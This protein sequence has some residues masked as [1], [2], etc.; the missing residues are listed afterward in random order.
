M[1][2]PR[3]VVFGYGPNGR[4]SL[5]ALD[6]L[7]VTP[8]AVVVPGNRTGHDIDVVRQFAGDRGWPVLEQPRRAA[9]APFLDTI[10]ALR[11]DLLFVWSYSMLLPA[12]LIGIAPLGAVNL[13]TG[14]LPEYRGGHVL[15]WAIINGERETGVT[16]AFLDEGVDTGPVIAERRFPIEWQDDAATVNE[17]LRV[18]GSELIR[19]WWPVIISGK[20]PR[21]PQDESR[22]R[23]YRM[24]GPDDGR[25]DWTQSNTDIYNLVRA[26]VAPWPGAFTDIDG[27][28]IVIRR[29]QPVDADRVVQPGTIVRVNGNEIDVAAGRGHVRLQAIELD[30]QSIAGDAFASVG[31]REGAAFG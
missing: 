19:Q 23:Y 2:D 10:R 26:L 9:L 22:A 29:V 20:A 28:R 31:L 14:L 27:R 25:I 7:G 3:V 17:K 1:P 13:H 24:R 8:A 4:E 16:L 30:S 15:N 11:P 18:A 6:Q 21:T 5:R 12:E